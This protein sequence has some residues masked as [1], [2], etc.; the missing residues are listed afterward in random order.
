[1]ELALKKLVKM[2]EYFYDFDKCINE[3]LHGGLEVSDIFKESHF[4]F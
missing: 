3:L 4:N 1:M 2:K